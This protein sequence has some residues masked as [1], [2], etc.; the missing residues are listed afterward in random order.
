MINLSEVDESQLMETL[1]TS[2]LIIV[3]SLNEEECSYEDGFELDQFHP[4]HPLNPLN[5]NNK[6]KE[7]VKEPLSKY[8]MVI[9]TSLKRNA[10]SK[11]SSSDSDSQESGDEHID[12]SVKLNKLQRSN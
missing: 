3:K 7:E 10:H 12:T 6:L 1:R 5:P 2:D 11:S 8:R 4:F 9:N